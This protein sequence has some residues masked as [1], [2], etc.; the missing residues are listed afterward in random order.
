MGTAF[1]LE[2]NRFNK[3]ACSPTEF[4]LESDGSQN[5]GRGQ[6]KPVISL[7]PSSFLTHLRGFTVCVDG[8]PFSMDQSSL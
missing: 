7:K 4:A 8:N 2:F 3:R 5:E 6:M 1:A